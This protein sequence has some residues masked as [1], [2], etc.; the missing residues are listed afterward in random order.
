MAVAFSNVNGN[1]G[2]ATNTGAVPMPTGVTAGDLLISECMLTASDQTL[3]V[4]AGWNIIQQA[5]LGGGNATGGIAYRIATGGSEAPQWSWGS[6]AAF[7][8]N[9]WRFTGAY[10]AAPIG[11]KQINVRAAGTTA[12]CSAINATAAASYMAS[13]N[14]TFNNQ[15]IP[16]PSGYTSQNNFSSASTSERMSKKD[17]TNVGDSS[18]A[19]TVTISSAK[20][21]SHLIE[22]RSAAP[23]NKPFRAQL[24]R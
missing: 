21:V 5:N 12:G 14:N 3:S 9:V 17:T 6:S 8:A 23:P 10:T 7:A 22:L 16:V 11:A 19:S 15:T 1:A 18:G 24:V 2:T 20:S 13:W 4:S